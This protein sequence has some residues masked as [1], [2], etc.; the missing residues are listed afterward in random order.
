MNN[1]MICAAMAQPKQNKAQKARDNYSKAV[2]K[3]KKAEEKSKET[4]RICTDMGIFIN[5]GMNK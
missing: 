5:D 4:R 2:E 3:A 1:E